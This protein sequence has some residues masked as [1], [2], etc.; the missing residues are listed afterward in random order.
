MIKLIKRWL[1]LHSQQ[2]EATITHD[3][4]H[5]RPHNTN[6]S[7]KVSLYHGLNGRILEIATHKSI[8][9]GHFT[10]SDWDFEFYSIPEGEAL[11]TAIATAFTLK[12]LSK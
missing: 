3:Y 11:S 10:H 4:K 6:P 2:M 9:Q 7:L 5:Q 1:S 8:S 12:E